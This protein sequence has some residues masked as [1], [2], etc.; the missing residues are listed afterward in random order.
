MK[1]KSLLQERLVSKKEPTLFRSKVRSRHPSHQILRSKLTLLPF[2]SVI[3]LGSTTEVNDKMG[4]KRIE[5]NSI[6]AIRNSSSK[7]RMKEA[8]TKAGVK[9]AKWL[10]TIASTTLTADNIEIATNSE[11]SIDFP[12]VA[13]S[14][15]GS[16]G[17]GNTLIKTI[18][19]F[20][21]WKKGKT[22][23]HYIFE[24]FHN[25]S[26]EY[27][28]H[29]TEE[30]CFYTCRKALKADVKEE[31]KWRRHDDICVWLM[32]ENPEFRKPSNWNDI[33][34][35]CVKA[36][37]AIGADVLSFDVKVQSATTAKGKKRDYQ[38]YILIECNS[39]SS[40]GD[41]TAAKYLIEIPKI[42]KRK[43]ATTN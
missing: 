4:V 34:T 23:A 1:K 15:F 10:K 6:E 7:L 40:F 21:A 29:I 19:E 5:C 36:L 41:V 38:D 16:R 27:R 3:R 33:I 31:D 30:G 28:L 9:T 43:Y 20:E 18:T 14:H 35:D 37:K 42:L 11:G 2:K 39:A 24:S 8:F 32:E 22:I 25:Y 26:L 13:K 17:N 12:I